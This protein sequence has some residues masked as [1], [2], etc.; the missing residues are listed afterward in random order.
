[1]AQIIWTEP[2]LE[3]L[4]A[5]IEYIALDNASAAS[6]L[7]AKVFLRVERLADH[8]GS[9][10]KPPELPRKSIFREIIVGPC[11]LFYFRDGE[12]VVVCHVMRGERELRR[13]LLSS[14]VD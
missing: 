12:K 5:V 4:E 9:G 14:N 10:R 6:Q 13:F 2:A 8:P 11:R 7:I 3:Q 1:M